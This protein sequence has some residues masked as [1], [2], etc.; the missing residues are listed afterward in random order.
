MVEKN[1]N[2]KSKM[3]YNDDRRRLTK[4]VTGTSF[5]MFIMTIILADA[6]VLGMMTSPTLSFYYDSLL[7]LFD[8]IFMGIFIIEMKNFSP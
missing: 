8:R 6:F 5:D 1:K 7:Y 4:L 3:Y 2:R